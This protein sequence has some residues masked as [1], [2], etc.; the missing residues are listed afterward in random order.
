MLKSILDM[1]GAQSQL[2][3]IF[4]CQN[5]HFYL[6]G[7]FKIIVLNISKKIPTI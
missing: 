6:C 5:R 3:G 7:C 2:M 4:E 1:I